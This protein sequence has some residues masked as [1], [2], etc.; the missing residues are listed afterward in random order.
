LQLGLSTN[1]FS[2]FL[3]Q[4]EYTKSIQEKTYTLLQQIKALK[5][6]L[7]QDQNT[8]QSNLDTLKTLQTQQLQTQSSLT[9]Q[10][11]GRVA[12]LNQTKGSESKYQKL[13]TQSQSEYAQINKEIN[14]LD[15]KASGKKGF[16]SLPVI[17]GILAWPLDGVVTQGY[18]NTGFTSLGYS[19]HNGID[20]AAPA[21][22]GISAAADG[23]VY[24]TGTGQTA[25]GNWVAIKHTITSQ[26]GHAIITLYGH[27]RSFI[28]SAG[29]TVKQ[30]DLI[31]Y[32]GNTGNTTRLLYGPDRGYH[33]HLSVFDADGFGIAP[34]AYQQTYGPYQV[35]YG[36]TYNP[37]DF[38]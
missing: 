28:V 8:L 4:V 38:L 34:G 36:Y 26:S 20:I 33:L 6:K 37:M 1:S 3:D 25:Y 30:G 31:G 32:E 11:N 13:L 9:E 15:Q 29:Q 10:K 23:V 35:P 5:D 2:D 16:K 24:A 17:H 22:T 21:G 19:F 27:L 14:D 12:L 7:Q 18:G